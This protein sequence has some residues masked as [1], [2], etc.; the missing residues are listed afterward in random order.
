MRTLSVALKIYMLESFTED[1]RFY[2]RSEFL[3]R[4]Q[5]IL[6]GGWL[7]CALQDVKLYPWPLSARW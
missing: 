5:I 1:N 7:S 3:N 4:D 6:H 2:S